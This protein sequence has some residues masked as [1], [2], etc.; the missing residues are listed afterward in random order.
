MW[1]CWP[2]SWTPAAEPPGAALQAA[3]VGV[4]AAAAAG[5]FWVPPALWVWPLGALGLLAGAVALRSGR[6]LLWGCFGV[7]LGFAAVAWAP[8]GT[9]GSTLPIRFTVTVRDGWTSG[10]WGWT[11]RVRV[12]EIEHVSGRI[13]TARE[14]R[15]TVGGNVTAAELPPPGSRCKGAGELAF[16]RELRLRAPVLRVKTRLLLDSAPPRWWSLDALRESLSSRLQQA[17][18]RQGLRPNGAALASALV[19]GRR[20]GLDREAVGA[21]RQAGLA[22]LLSVSGLHVVLVSTLVWLALTALGLQPRTRR[23]ALVPALVVF[24]LVSGGSAP[25]LRATAANIGYLLT[26]L[27]G[28]PVLPLPA[29]WSVV[30]ALVV[31]EPAALL[32][33]GFQLSAGVSLALVRWA[34]WLAERLDVLPRWLAA[35]LSVAVVAQIA[36][37]PLVGVAFASVPP[38]GA[39][40]NLAAAPL[41]FPLVG[42]SVL[43]ASLGA[44]STSLAGPL[45]WLVGAVNVVL[46]RVAEWGGGVSWLFAA[47]QAP[48]LAAGGICL[49]LGTVVWRRAWMPAMALVVG[50]IAWTVA[51]APWPAGRCELRMLPVT[52]GTAILVRGEG[53][54]VLVDTGRGAN[55]A[56]RGLAAARVRRLDALILTHADADHIGGAPALLERGRVGE[57]VIPAAT[58][59]QDEIKPLLN[60]A[61]RRGVKVREVVAGDRL[62]WQELSGL[63]VWPTDGVK[64]GD[65]DL[66]LVAVLELGGKRVLLTGDIE[67]AGEAALVATGADLGADILQLPHHGSRTSSSPRLLSAA[68]PRVALAATGRRPRFAYPDA[69]VVSRVRRLPALVVAQTWG[70]ERIWWTGDGSIQIGT[71]VPVHVPP[72]REAF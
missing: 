68:R 49:V 46:V 40:A 8:H 17:A 38:L 32:Q 47:P 24:A 16:D 1:K 54:R 37:W 64:M 53:A 50:S 23:I 62:A 26:R 14:L 45:V 55:E 52:D 65:N 12:H 66:S 15:L 41:A 61:R 67:A 57:L 72:R 5:N 3:A 9:P 21:L 43:A 28:R 60:I 51:P 27:S 34:G 2:S 69:R 6:L 44:L 70:V 18:P 20:E 25:V 11:T 13:R 39:V 63:V 33:P 36:S 29:M 31:I 19:L 48:L 30:A 58:M 71:R 7:A 4:V 35:G 10:Q 22:H 56:L 42:L 59:E